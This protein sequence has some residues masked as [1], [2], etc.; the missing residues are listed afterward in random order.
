MFGL[1]QK[2]IRAIKKAIND[3]PEIERAIVFGSRAMGN[4]KKGSDIDI[5]ISGK[6]VNSKTVLR[7]S[8]NLNEISPLPYFFDIIHYEKILNTVLKKRID[9]IGIEI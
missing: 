9:E 3:C 5:A 2:N 6:K 7:L 4:Y 1:L 8:E